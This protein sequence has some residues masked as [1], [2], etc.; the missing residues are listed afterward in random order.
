LIQRSGFR[1][2]PVPLVPEPEL[3]L[4]LPLELVPVSLPMVEPVG[5]L[6]CGAP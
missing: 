4:V 2:L 3:G 5:A 1:L 6:L